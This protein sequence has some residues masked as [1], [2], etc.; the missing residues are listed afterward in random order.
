MAGYFI[1][2]GGIWTRQPLSPAEIDSDN[3]LCR[4]LIYA[5]NPAFANIAYSG[6]AV[7][8]ATPQGIAVQGATGTA[9]AGLV[10]GIKPHGNLIAA[11]SPRSA[12]V[13]ANVNTYAS[14]PFY[15]AGL[16][17]STDV[18]AAHSA[19]IWSNN[20]AA[21]GLSWNL[22][23]R[24]VTAPAAGPVIV[25]ASVPGSGLSSNAIVV[26]NG[27]RPADTAIQSGT[28]PAQLIPPKILIAGRTVDTLRSLNGY[29]SLAAFWNRELSEAEHIELYKNPWQI[30]KPQQR[31]IWV[32]VSAGGVSGTLAYTNANDTLSATGTTTV[33]G[34]LAKTNENDTLSSSG[35]TTVVCTLAYTNADDTLSASGSVGNDVTGTVNY[36][37]ANDTLSAS[38]TTTVTG[39]VAY[40]NVNDTLSGA[41]SPIIVGN[42]A[43]TNANDTL[44]ASGA[45]G[46]VTGI[47]A[48]TNANDTLHADGQSGYPD[49]DTSGAGWPIYP[50]KPRKKQKPHVRIDDIIERSM[51]EIYEGVIEEAPQK[52][53]KQ[54]A[55][56]VR[57]YMEKGA[58]P[59]TIPQSSAIDWMGLERDAER[60]SA[61]LSIWQEQMEAREEAREEEEILLLLM[62]A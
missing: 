55:R 24:Y 53:R 13:V 61:L 29:V 25:S 47:I 16:Q 2:R 43:Y 58:K 27:I 38:G 46:T 17:D 50:L 8:V 7:R 37:N 26:V 18:Q 1:T 41:G 3:P 60:V 21:I 52:V 54:A 6:S 34:T 10:T 45:A 57:P 31:R 42:L 33:T 23:F 56:I 59:A 32:P 14:A 30:F 44:A 19:L 4:G 40:T 48:Y 9:S 28:P 49:A 12:L 11:S 36:T 15:F 35:T 20:S 39:T 51:R 22:G 5:I 62:A